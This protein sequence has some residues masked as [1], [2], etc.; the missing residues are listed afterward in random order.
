MGALCHNTAAKR[1]WSQGLC[2]SMPAKRGY[3]S[4]AFMAALY[5][6]M[7]STSLKMRACS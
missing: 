6:L 1:T 2:V 5:F 7:P 4:P 3:M